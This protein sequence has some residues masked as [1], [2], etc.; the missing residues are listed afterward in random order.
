MQFFYKFEGNSSSV[1]FLSLCNDFV[2][3]LS[4]FAKFVLISEYNWLCLFNVS[5]SDYLYVWILTTILLIFGTYIGSPP[6]YSFSFLIANKKKNIYRFSYNYNSTTWTKD[7][8]HQPI[9]SLPATSHPNTPSECVGKLPSPL[10]KVQIAIALMEELEKHQLKIFFTK[11][12][13]EITPLK[14]T[15]ISNTRILR[16]KLSTSL[17]LCFLQFYVV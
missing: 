2:L 4:L 16:L 7:T 1:D 14:A 8:N 15:S 5:V 9:Y 10:R 12:N 13:S 17:S 11:P 3:V 6:S